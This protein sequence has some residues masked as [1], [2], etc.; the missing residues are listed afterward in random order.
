MT[1]NEERVSTFIK[2]ISSF[3]KT[4]NNHLQDA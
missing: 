1:F 3:L 4:N 2:Q